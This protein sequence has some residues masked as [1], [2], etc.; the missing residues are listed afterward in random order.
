[1]NAITSVVDFVWEHFGQHMIV[2][3]NT[4]TTA[5]AVLKALNGTHPMVTT[6]RERQ[7]AKLVTAREAK[8][9][10]AKALK[11]WADAAAKWNAGHEL[12]D[13]PVLTDDE[14][15]ILAKACTNGKIRGSGVMTDQ[16]LTT[17]CLAVIRD[18]A[19]SVLVSPLRPTN[20]AGL[21]TR[22]C[23]GAESYVATLL[24]QLVDKPP[25]G[26]FVAIEFGKKTIGLDQLNLNVPGIDGVAVLR[27]SGQLGETVRRARL[28]DLFALL[29]GHHVDLGSLRRLAEWEQAR[30]AD[31]TD[32][33]FDALDK[34]SQ[35]LPEG[36]DVDELLDLVPAPGTLEWRLLAARINADNGEN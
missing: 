5:D 26:P 12:L 29:D 3:S 28:L 21:D 18:D 23:D 14:R 30:I 1:M 17:Y 13:D 19:P 11:D 16:R 6:D 32:P 27:T 22:A 34:L 9:E 4:D 35:K 25:A 20:P 31:P 33:N 15:T 24:D 10:K 7:L 36:L 8:K 2:R